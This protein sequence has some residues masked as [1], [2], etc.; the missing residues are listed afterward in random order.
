MGD[1]TVA[2]Y[3]V[4]G[5]LDLASDYLHE[6]RD[7]ASRQARATLLVAVDDERAD[8]DSDEATGAEAT[9]D[10][11]RLLGTVTFCLAGTPYANLARAGEAEFRMLAVSPHARGRGVGRGLTERCVE[12]AREAGAESLVLCSME[13]MTRAHEIYRRAGFQRSPERD[14]DPEPGLT[15]LTFRLPL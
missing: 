15:L 8:E 13:S 12:L 10:G 4:D 5:H 11:T 3:T 1:L 14:W 7:A 2:A 6:L 9:G